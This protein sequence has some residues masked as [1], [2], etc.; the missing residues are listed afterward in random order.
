[1]SLATSRSENFASFDGMRQRQRYGSRGLRGSIVRLVVDRC[2]VAYPSMS[3]HPHGHVNLTQVVHGDLKPA[4]VLL[5]G[6]YSVKLCDFGSA[7]TSVLLGEPADAC[8]EPPRM[9]AAAS[10]WYCAPESLLG[11]PA[12]PASD[13]W[14]LGKFKN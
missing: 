3:S 14:A 8:G 10:R 1:M 6:Q 7:G 5:T 4:N 13:V 2:C 11:S 9:T 12:S